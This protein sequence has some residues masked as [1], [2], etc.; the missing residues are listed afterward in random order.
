MVNELNTPG[1]FTDMIRKGNY[2]VILDVE[3]KD[4]Q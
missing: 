2:P 3:L 1:A 4:L